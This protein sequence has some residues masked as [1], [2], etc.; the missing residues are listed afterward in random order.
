MKRLSLRLKNFT[1]TTLTA[2][3]SLFVAAGVHAQGKQAIVI[4]K[5]SA[6]GAAV[7]GCDGT[8]ELNYQIISDVK[9]NSKDEVRLVN[10]L[11]ASSDSTSVGRDTYEHSGKSKLKD[12]SIL[13]WN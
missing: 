1:L 6:S 11:S 4:L 2:C 13:K 12:L 5:S 8:A 7:A 3:L 9:L 10:G